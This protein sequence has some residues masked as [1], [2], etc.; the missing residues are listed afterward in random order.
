MAEAPPGP[1]VMEETPSED[2]EE[3]ECEYPGFDKAHGFPA[4]GGAAST[5]LAICRKMRPA[6][7]PQGDLPKRA[8]SQLQKFKKLLDSDSG[9]Q[10]KVELLRYRGRAIRRWNA[11][12]RA[13]EKAAAGVVDDGPISYP[14][15]GEGLNVIAGAL[16]ERKDLAAKARERFGEDLNMQEL[17]QKLLK[18]TASEDREL[19]DKLLAHRK[20]RVEARRKALSSAGGR[21]GRYGPLASTTSQTATRLVVVSWSDEIG[22]T[23]D[24]TLKKALDLLEYMPPEGAEEWYAIAATVSAAGGRTYTGQQC[25]G[26]AS[27]EKMLCPKVSA[28]WTYQPDSP[29]WTPRTPLLAGLEPSLP[30]GAAARPDLE[31]LSPDELY[32][33]VGNLYNHDMNQ[34]LGDKDACIEVLIESNM[35]AV[36]P[37]KHGAT[38]FER[39]NSKAFRNAM[40]GELLGRLA[41]AKSFEATRQ[42]LEGP[43]NARPANGQD[44]V[45]R[46][47]AASRKRLF[48]NKALLAY[49]SKYAPGPGEDPPKTEMSFLVGHFTEA[50]YAPHDVYDAA[51]DCAICLRLYEDTGNK[52]FCEHAWD[53]INELVAIR[54]N[55]ACRDRRT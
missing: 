13:E 54:E 2:D 18:S 34:L 45:S 24:D 14:E 8:K 4:T 39:A 31:Q 40:R 1:V 33:L 23:A 6:V 48:A 19:I 55:G 26:R 41:V 25:Y 52:V 42:R 20:A 32:Y 9:P 29:H 37:R 22:K 15:V 12:C 50:P 53:V 46:T 49:R 3:V 28:V 27:K 21:I 36:D 5:L 44:E 17:G 35:P 51:Q 16:A 38:A 10:L 43:E 7:V 11:K 47:V 30:R